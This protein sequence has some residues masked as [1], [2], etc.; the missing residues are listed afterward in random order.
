MAF[1]S[2]YSN[3]KD[4]EE[5]ALIVGFDFDIIILHGLAVN[6]NDIGRKS[7]ELPGLLSVLAAGSFHLE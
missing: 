4:S 7:K 3:L 1:E 6:R 2:V 5:D